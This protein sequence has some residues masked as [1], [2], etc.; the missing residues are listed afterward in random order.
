[1]DMFHC[2][3][4]TVLDLTETWHDTDCLVFGRFFDAGFSVV[5]SPR[6]HVRD[7][8]TVSHG[9]VAIVTAPGTSVS[10]LPVGSLPSTFEVVASFVT[11]GRQ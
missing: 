8:L 1:M 11:S 3:Q 4:F 6:P 5:G 10:P 2:H 9:G 7:D